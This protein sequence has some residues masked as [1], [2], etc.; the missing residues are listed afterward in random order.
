M[1]RETTRVVVLSWDQGTPA[2]VY[3]EHCTHLY[4]IEGIEMGKPKEF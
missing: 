4:H 2:P 3:F 1:E